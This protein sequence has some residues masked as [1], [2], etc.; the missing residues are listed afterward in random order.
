MVCLN[1]LYSLSES[2]WLPAMCQYLKDRMLPAVQDIAVKVQ[3]TASIFQLQDKSVKEDCL[4]IMRVLNHMDE[5]GTQILY[6]EVPF[7][8]EFVQWM[9]EEFSYLEYPGLLELIYLRA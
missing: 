1:S 6:L 7:C 4:E 9:H 3:S 2:E 5:D 8:A